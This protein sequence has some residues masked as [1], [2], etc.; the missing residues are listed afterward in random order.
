MIDFFYR[1]SRKGGWGK[2]LDEQ[3]GFRRVARRLST[4]LDGDS[5]GKRSAGRAIQEQTQRVCDALPTNM[6]RRR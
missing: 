6:L 4:D 3:R 1:L 5:A 2:P